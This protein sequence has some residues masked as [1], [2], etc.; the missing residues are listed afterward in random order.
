MGT[1]VAIALAGVLAVASPALAQT[2]RLG[3]QGES[4]PLDTKDPA[5]DEYFER[6][7][8]LIRKQWVYP[9][10]RNEAEK[11]CEYKS[12]S[13]VADFGILRDGA[14]AFVEI[15][16]SSGEPVYDQS[17]VDALKLAAPFPAV[18]PALMARVPPGSA[19]VPLRMRFHYKVEQAA[20]A[21]P[22]P[23]PLPATPRG[24]SVAPKA[25][26]VTALAGAVAARR[27]GAS[28]PLKVGDEVVIADLITTAA[29]ARVTMV[30]GGRATVVVEER[31]TLKLTEIPGSASL[32]LYVGRL[33][34]TLDG[35]QLRP[36]EVVD[37]RTP[38]AIATV[39]GTRMIVE[40]I[41]P[42]RPGGPLV[43]HVDVLDGLTSVM[44]IPGTVGS[45]IEIGRASCRERV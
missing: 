10:V 41:P 30:L 11:I 23:S 37:V 33:E 26:V 28:V 12:V 15:Q 21:P 7:R 1:M 3:I 6:L 14:L 19:G 31:A 5:V 29:G 39:P 38:N 18:P 13:L 8:S 44:A 34:V 16:T 24:S 25:G 17:A 22:A 2:D 32:D 35:A 40:T 9:C 4:I 43:T 45:A 36:R 27:A 20:S 42:A